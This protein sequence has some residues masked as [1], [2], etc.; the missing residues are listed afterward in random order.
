[1][2][3]FP[4]VALRLV[5][6]VFL[7]V[8]PVSI[9]A[10]QQ[11]NVR[12]GQLSFKNDDGSVSLATHLG[13]QMRINISGIV[14]QVTLKQS[15]TNQ[16]SDWQ[17]AVYLFPLEETAAVNFMQ[18][19]VGNRLIE[20]QIR[21]KQ[22]ARRIYRAAK[23]AG[24]KAALTEQSRSNMFTQSIA[25]IAPG[26]TIEVELRYIQRVSY[27]IGKF[28][29][30][31]PTTLTPRHIAG[32]PVKGSATSGVR[33]TDLVP[34]AREISPPMIRAEEN[35]GNSNRVRI[36]I[37]L[38]STL[39]LQNISSPYHAIEILNREQHRQI[40]LKNS[41]A[42][43]DRDFVLNWQL[44]P[45]GAP[46]S[47]V[48]HETV[49]GE[50]YLLLMIMPPSGHLETTALPKEM[51]FVIDTSGSMKGPSINQAKQSLMDAISRLQPNDIFNVI[52]FNSIATSLFPHS[53]RADQ[54]NM[55]DAIQ[56]VAM[57]EAN[58]GTNMVEAFVLAMDTP[59]SEGFLKQIIFITDGAIA[60][61]QFLLSIIHQILGSARLFTVGIGAAPNGHFMRKAAEFGR[62]TF[63]YIGKAS[64]AGE[65]MEALYRKINHPVAT[66]IDIQ[67]P[68]VAEVYPEKLPA[69]YLGEPLLV[70]AKTQN[71]FGELQVS[72][73]TADSIWRKSLSLD[74][75]QNHPG[76]A[77]L[78]ARAKIENL[79][80]GIVE[81]RP[82]NAA[83]K[84]IIKVALTHSLI[85]NYTSLVAVESYVSR[86]PH[87]GVLTNQVPGVLPA[88][89][90]MTSIQYPRT[91]TN[92]GVSLIVGLV[93]LVSAMI[94]VA[95]RRRVVS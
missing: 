42:L 24:N 77:S 7:I 14:A 36:T 83:R 66:D 38:D 64:E 8:K 81:G 1:M 63:T 59:E 68:F 27:E 54:Q 13:T 67:W 94:L 32:T 6:Y 65:K 71:L 47:V 51:I 89:T 61:E 9:F 29:L 58:G 72:G 90:R 22:E 84:D 74:R 3:T 35:G 93:S 10:D 73:S 92:A 69:L 25:N 33:A 12:A 15:F 45:D 91:A 44:A 62:G 46:V 5:L 4:L 50:D 40:S 80:D 76:V 70:V 43:M 20:A 28:S 53:R 41:E 11:E 37:N 19:R 55:N 56:A 21:E 78:W 30:R 57:L 23:K 17:E 39:P 49:D 95:I 16:T 79:E 34:D 75:T 85:S 86:F 26:E 82:I 48:Y 18:M 87:D 88:G 31:L 60:N 2:Q 52:E